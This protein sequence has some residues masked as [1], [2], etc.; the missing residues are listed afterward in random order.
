M[1]VMSFSFSAIAVKTCDDNGRLRFA[2]GRL[3]H[4]IGE[5]ELS[6]RSYLESIQDQLGYINA[7]KLPMDFHNDEKNRTR[8]FLFQQIY[9]NV[10]VFGRYI[11]IHASG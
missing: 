7:H 11:R 9:K 4:L 3:H 1:V 10:P 5:L 8:H 2:T 6:V